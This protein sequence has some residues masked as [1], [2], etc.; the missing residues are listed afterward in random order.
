MQAIEGCGEALVLG[1]VGQ[2]IA[3]ELP[4]NELIEWKILIERF[5]HPIAI[6]PDRASTIHLVAMRI[7]KTREVQP[8]RR[9]P[10]SKAR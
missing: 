5:D 3:R 9:H 8:L 2:Q 7:R 10:F 1:G 6:R 4:R